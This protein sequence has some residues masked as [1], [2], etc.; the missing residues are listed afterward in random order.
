MAVVNIFIST[1]I[2]VDGKLM[3]RET[4]KS[5]DTLITLSQLLIDK[6]E[7]PK[8]NVDIKIEKI[9]NVENTIIQQRTDSKI[10]PILQPIYIEL[11]NND[12]VIENKNIS[13][14]SVN[15][16][17]YLK[18]NSTKNTKEQYLLSKLT[19]DNKYFFDCEDLIPV[20]EETTYVLTDAITNKII[21]NGKV[22]VAN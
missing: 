18:I 3:K 1:E 11:I 15:N 8:T 2:N 5:F 9:E 20:E 4:M 6:V 22:L 12:I 10:I 14:N 21:G 19:I 7:F 16:P 13:F 17:T